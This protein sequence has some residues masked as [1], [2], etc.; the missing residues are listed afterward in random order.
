MRLLR[1]L[2]SEAGE[3]SFAQ[4]GLKSYLKTALEN[5]PPGHQGALRRKSNRHRSP[6][7]VGMRQEPGMGQRR[8]GGAD[9]RGKGEAALHLQREHG[10]R[11]VV[12]QTKS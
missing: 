8:R 7:L 5:H 2:A 3:D 6:C 10:I 11:G 9:R 4:Y 1:C 12:A